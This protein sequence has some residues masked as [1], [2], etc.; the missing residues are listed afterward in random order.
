THPNLNEPYTDEGLERGFGAAKNVSTDSLRKD[1]SAA[2]GW[3]NEQDFVKPGKVATWG[4]C[5]GG[6]VAFLTANLPGLAGA[7]C[8]YGG[9]IAAPMPNGEPEAL[10]T[11]ED[12]RVPLLLAY[13]GQDAW[14]TM[15]HINRTRA[16]LDA[17][18][19]DFQ[20]QIYPTVGHAFF[21]GSSSDLQSDTVADAWNVVQ[22]FLKKIFS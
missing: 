2:I 18:G 21:R 7:I 20:M 4:F 5:F 11:V 9:S 14:I 15:D 19:K 22:A 13:G 12:I 6:T 3:L 10:A 16:A 1:C 8:F 17:A